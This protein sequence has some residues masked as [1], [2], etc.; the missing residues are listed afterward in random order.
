[1][2]IDISNRPNKNIR[3]VT[4]PAKRKNMLSFI[5]IITV[6]FIS[7]FFDCLADLLLSVNVSKVLYVLLKLIGQVSIPLICFITS[8]C[9]MRTKKVKNLAITLGIAAIISHIPYVIFSTGKFDLLSRTSLMFPVLLGYSA[10]L[11]RDMPAVDRNVKSAIILLSCLIAMAGEGGSIVVVWIY[12]FGSGFS[13][14]KKIKYF[15]IAG[16]VM[17]ILNLIVSISSEAWYIFIY[18]LGIFLALPFIVNTNPAKSKS[19]ENDFYTICFY[20]VIIIIFAVIKC[21][22]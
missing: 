4:I 13:M 18:Q 8:E 15:S 16:I 12:I 10:L 14:N 6:A 17:V 5:A 9:Y 21:I 3:K 22:L 7:I 20:P 2:A 19:I 1:M 11:I